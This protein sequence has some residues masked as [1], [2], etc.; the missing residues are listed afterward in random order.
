MVGKI[1]INSL[2]NG[3]S[4]TVRII[5]DLGNGDFRVTDARETASN[6]QLIRR[7]RTW[8]APVS[9]LQVIG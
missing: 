5:A 8:A 4:V 1:A 9:R 6:A 2:S 3:S 7:N